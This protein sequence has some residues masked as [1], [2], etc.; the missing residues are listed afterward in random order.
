LHIV[1]S[2]VAIAGFFLFI[3]ACMPS[4]SPDGSQLVFDYVRAGTKECGIALY[5]TATGKAT[6]IYTY[7][8]K[9]SSQPVISAQWREDGRTVLAFVYD[10]AAPSEERSFLAEVAP[11]GDV[12]RIIK[13]N[14]SE[15][16]FA[17]AAEVRR[18]LYL[19]GDH[20]IKVDLGSG[21]YKD[22]EDLG[23]AYFFR[24]NDQV[25]FIAKSESMENKDLFLIGSLESDSSQPHNS[26][27]FRVPNPSESDY[28]GFVPPP[29]TDRTGRIALPVAREDKTA[30]IVICDQQ[31]LQ[32]IIEP[33]L[34]PHS[35]IGNLQWSPDGNSLYA[36][37]LGAVKKNTSVW[38][39]AEINA[40]TGD[41]VRIVPV[42]QM[43]ASEGDVDSS[44][45]HHFPIALSPDGRTIA[46]NLAGAPD[47]SVSE[48]DRA[49]YLLDLNGDSAKVTKVPYPAAK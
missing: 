17:P 7:R 23:T 18:V 13:L 42:S 10:D 25:A 45:F 4:W 3:T 41:I 40:E 49:L 30:V 46:T 19:W 47:K 33:K 22:I 43:N 26:T 16:Y 32:R 1:L 9:G 44:F 14:Q 28:N 31:G 24:A 11:N 6:S 2:L 48:T 27:E 5:D 35:Q 21:E 38:S 39:I 29:A 15:G 37:V 12:V 36:G 20:P 8:P 34:D